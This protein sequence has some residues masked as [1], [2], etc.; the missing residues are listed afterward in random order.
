MAKGNR[1]Q[2]TLSPKIAAE[3]ER[4]AKEKGVTKSAIVTLALG[5]YIEKIMK[6]EQLTF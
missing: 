1:L 3:L 5:E 4:L 2:L 6:G